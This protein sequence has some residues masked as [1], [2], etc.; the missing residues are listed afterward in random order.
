MA[1]IRILIADDH[2][3][4]RDGLR[5]LIEGQRDMSVVAEA[6]DGE[7]AARLAR[8]LRPDV[9]VM[10]LSMPRCGGVEAI[11][12]MRRW[13]LP[14]RALVLSMYDDATY[15]RAALAAG[16]AGYLPKRVASRQLIEA[17]RQVHRHHS[18]IV[19]ALNDGSLQQLVADPAS[20]DQGPM[21]RLTEREFEVLELVARGHTHAEIAE[22]LQLSTK[23]IDTYRQRV[24]Q[25]LG[26]RTRAELVRFA[27]ETGVLAPLRPPDSSTGE[28]EVD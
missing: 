12:R 28:D 23:T 9:A 2:A 24:G 4:F 3:V 22:R 21:A 19:V 17:I 7:Q 1:T 18:Y 5:T 27:I 26:L 8:E 10:D 25:K 16:A 14:T 13:K 6:S 11:T 20:V 15:V